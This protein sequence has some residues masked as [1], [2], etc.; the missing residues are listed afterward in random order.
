[1][2]RCYSQ[3]TTDGV[4]PLLNTRKG[5]NDGVLLLL[6]TRNGGKMKVLG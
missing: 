1:M 6:N 4:L 3:H 2:L 5:R